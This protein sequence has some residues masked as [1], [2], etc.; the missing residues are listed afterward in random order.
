MYSPADPAYGTHVEC[1]LEILSTM[2]KTIPYL[3]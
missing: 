3:T 1:I 2:F